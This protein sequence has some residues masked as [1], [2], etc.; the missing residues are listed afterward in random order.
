MASTP[1]VALLRGINV[2]GNHIVKMTDLKSCFESLG[3]RDVATFIQS[4]NVVF[5]APAGDIDKLAVKI[6][7]TLEK[8]YGFAVPT[9]LV[10]GAQLRAAVKNA[11]KGFGTQP[12]MYHCDV[13]FLRKPLTPTEAMKA[14][15]L[16][17]GVDTAHAGK[18][19]LYFSR[20]S[21]R[22]TQSHLSKLMG[23]AA[24]KQMTIRNW[25][26]TTKLLALIDAM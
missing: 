17:E 12:D 11:P 1:C 2:G 5:T 14:L 26:T 22:R 9:V 10:P 16:K 25:N 19:A 13:I 3:L 18:D 21:S 4:G 15:S 23:K 20:L 24:Y 7:K 8:R 6:E